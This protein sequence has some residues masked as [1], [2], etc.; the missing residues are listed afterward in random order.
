VNKQELEG[1]G[2]RLNPSCRS[3]KGQRRVAY[4]GGSSWVLAGQRAAKVAAVGCLEG[5]V[6]QRRLGLEARGLQPA[7]AAGLIH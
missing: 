7:R 1:D 6:P 5:T 4:P 3:S 2:W